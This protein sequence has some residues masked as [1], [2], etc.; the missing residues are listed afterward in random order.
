MTTFTEEDRISA[1][2]ERMKDISE[3]IIFAKRFINE[4]EQLIATPAVIDREQLFK[5]SIEL[6]EAT[7]QVLIEADRIGN[8]VG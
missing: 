8:D 4:M 3:H 2:K 5:K 1:Q 7:A 6:H